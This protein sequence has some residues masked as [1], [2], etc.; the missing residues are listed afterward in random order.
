MTLSLQ[1]YLLGGAKSFGFVWF[2]FAWGWCA[3]EGWEDDEFGFEF[4][5]K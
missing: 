1:T 2:L 3:F 5:I 4:T